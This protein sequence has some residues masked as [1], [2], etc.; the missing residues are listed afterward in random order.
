[1]GSELLLLGPLHIFWSLILL[2]VKEPLPKGSQEKVLPFVPPLRLATQSSTGRR[3]TA[4]YTGQ[5][6]VQPPSQSLEPSAYV[7]TLTLGPADLSAWRLLRCVQRW[8]PGGRL[9]SLLWV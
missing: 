2:S 6:V 3:G 5:G 1:M 7:T 4:S 9:G 8:S